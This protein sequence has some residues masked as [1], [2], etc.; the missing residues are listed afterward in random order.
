MKL[1]I[2]IVTKSATTTV[3]VSDAESYTIG[4]LAADILVPDEDCSRAHALLYK[5]DDGTLRIKDLNSTN[6]TKIQGKKIQEATL[7]EGT[8]VRI[9]HTLLIPVRIEIE[10]QSST[11]N[12]VGAD[13]GGAKA[14]EKTKPDSMVV[15]NQWPDNFRS[16]PKAK[17][18]E[19]VDMI[20]EKSRK[21]S[22]RLA[23]IIKS[24]KP[25]K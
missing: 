22:V 10:G 3:D 24:R 11:G 17:L 20:D 5:A 2:K 21:N 25:G 7:V 23:D 16:F 19:Y 1:S 12:E 8:E 4:R 13:T 18:E 9:G 14:S 15:L 6:G